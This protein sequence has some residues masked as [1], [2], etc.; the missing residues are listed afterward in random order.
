MKRSCLVALSAAFLF[1]GSLLPA[2][3]SELRPDSGVING[4][5]YM[6]GYFGFSYRFPEGWMGNAAVQRTIAVRQMVPLFSANPQGLGASD[7]RYVSINADFLPPNSTLKS[8]KEFL[9][10]AAQTLSEA[11]DPLHT[12]KRCV[13]AGK[14]FY[15][16]DMKSRMVP[17]APV[18][19]Q[20]QITTF[21][22]SYAVT[23]SFMA[24]NS[25]DMAELVRTMESLAFFEP[26]ELP[27]VPGT[28][29]QVAEK[30]EGHSQ[31]EAKP[32]AASATPVQITSATPIAA[33]ANV[34]PSN[35]EPKNVDL[36]TVQPRNVEP[37][38]AFSAPIAT[39]AAKPEVSASTVPAQNAKQS[40]PTA[41]QATEHPVVA[42][43]FVTSV[44]RVQIMSPPAT[45]L[46]STNVEA[47][48]ASANDKAAATPARQAP[49]A[50]TATTVSEPAIVPAAMPA[51]PVETAS[52]APVQ[53]SPGQAQ[54]TTVSSN[55]PDRIQPLAA[56]VIPANAIPVSPV[57]A[58]SGG[59]LGTMAESA[60]AKSAT[61]ASTGAATA[62]TQKKAAYIPSSLASPPAA[63]LPERVSVVSEDAPAHM[64]A[65]QTP[66]STL[67]QATRR[68]SDG[69]ATSGTAAPVTTSA[70]NQHLPASVQPAAAA[71]S[72]AIAPP[73]A[74]DAGPATPEPKRASGVTTLAMNT[75]PAPIAT[76][77]KPSRVQVSTAELEANLTRKT[78]PVYPMVAKNFKV[79][80]LVVVDVVV[81]RNGNVL[82]AKAL[83]GPQL[84]LRGAEA[85]VR[86]WHFKPYM[87][88]G[89]PVEMESQVSLSYRLSR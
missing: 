84:L 6:N 68:P 55:L 1:A 87:V 19:Y 83:S 81:D 53:S 18:V 73:P 7:V 9:E 88:D 72:T 32:T 20:T 49:P 70:A 35:A 31:S 27:A 76:T 10:L 60:P 40:R 30:S 15:R 48:M 8:P 64:A 74:A 13:F 57:S 63:A 22:R 16:I 85:A 12:D 23:F 5:R 62:T 38:P 77:A 41:S 24:S 89:A 82:E 42:N 86:Q 43:S 34:T 26:G 46:P 56:P 52:G 36:Q 75:P 2:Q 3:D 47:R 21:L 14:Q 39:L 59:S 25:D 51:H 66:P 44:P 4:R 50:V 65:S 61:I 54:V 80:G 33:P 71:P 67:I 45:P 17:G 69:S 58:K 11:F 79:E 37:V 28:K 78:L 29:V